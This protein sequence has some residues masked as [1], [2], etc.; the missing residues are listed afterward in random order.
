MTVDGVAIKCSRV[1]HPDESCV[2]TVGGTYRCLRGQ[3]SSLIGRHTTPRAPTS[4]GSLYDTDYERP[5]TSSP[6]LFTYGPSYVTA[7]DEPNRSRTNDEEQEQDGVLEQDERC[8]MGYAYNMNNR[9][10]EGKLW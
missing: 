5:R 2:L 1:C 3:P 6:Q 8:V 7:T 10:C 4:T 9:L